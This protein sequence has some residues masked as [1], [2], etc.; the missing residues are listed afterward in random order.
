MVVVSV[1]LAIVF[2]RHSV[3]RMHHFIDVLAASSYEL[4][5]YRYNLN[6]FS[7][8]ILALRHVLGM[9]FA[10]VVAL[11]LFYGM[12]WFAYGLVL[13]VVVLFIKKQVFAHYSI[14]TF[15]P[16]KRQLSFAMGMFLWSLPVLMGSILWAFSIKT[17][18]WAFFV[19]G[20]LTSDIAIPIWVGITARFL[21][22]R[23]RR[24]MRRNLRWVK[25]V[26]RSRKDLGVVF[27]WGD[28]ASYCAFVQKMGTYI[29]ILSTNGACLDIQD[30]ALTMKAELKPEHRLL[31]IWGALESDHPE[32]L[33]AFQALVKICQVDV[34][35]V[36]E[37]AD[38]IEHTPILLRQIQV[39]DAILFDAENP[40]TEKQVLLSEGKNWLISANGRA[41]DLQ[42]FDD[43]ED[44][45]WVWLRDDR[46][47]WY[48]LE[49]PQNFDKTQ[50]NAL[51]CMIGL[52]RIAG[53][54]PPF[55][56]HEQPA[57][58]YNKKR[59][60]LQE[61]MLE[62]VIRANMDNT[63]VK[64]ELQVFGE[65]Y[66]GKVRDTYTK[67]E[68][69]ILV[70]TDR[71]SAFDHVLAEAIPFKGQV[72]NQLAAYFFKHTATVVPNHVL[73]VP[74]PNVT[75]GLRLQIVPIEFVVRGYLAGHAARTYI[76]GQRELC[77]IVLPEGLVPHQK[78][79]H[80]IL[81]PTTKAAQGHDMD[82]H[83]EEVLARG[84]LT[85]S[86]WE[87]LANMALA[88]FE[89][90][91]EMARE[92]GLLLV[93]TKYEFGRTRDGRFV[94]ADEVHTPDSS[95]YY[96]ADSYDALFASRQTPRQ[97][98]KEFVREWL[99]ERGFQGREG[100]LMPHLDE[101]FRETVALRYMELYER[102]TGEA[103]VPDTH[104]LPEVR[105]RENMMYYENGEHI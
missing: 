58:F 73:A 100:E 74:D 77:G 57:F 10:G 52:M 69:V 43:P 18:G 99:M 103:F 13:M 72:L 32:A 46:S 88:L 45:H 15:A 78:L 53:N 66:Q 29:S 14:Q 19:L 83:R 93:D 48:R 34:Y 38:Q 55:T 1:V 26:L 104:P 61:P 20:W 35:V 63:L 30:L 50:A 27:F 82:T 84:I 23:R 54:E 12:T 79:P 64:T 62:E 98:S 97:L 60:K 22:W 75:I 89:K 39:S 65:K 87:E 94:L 101:T 105:I 47:M 96:L 81:T 4:D 7:S 76:N 85:A 5:G 25:R 56:P 2:L 70:A 49:K 51:L 86:E 80:P 59:L 31:V 33:R 8:Q 102:I 67:E 40:Q 42:L 44:G 16:E 95:R 41:A 24:A 28:Q 3:A 71:I 21:S 92:R 91:S 9:I 17:T 68:R 11:L 6:K 37:A 36:L 90:G